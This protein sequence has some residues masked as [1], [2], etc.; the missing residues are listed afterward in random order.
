[1]R[2]PLNPFVFR[3]VT[4]RARAASSFCGEMS[5]IGRSH[6]GERQADALHCFNHRIL[7]ALNNGA[8]SLCT[9]RAIINDAA[10]AV[11]C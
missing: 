1:M 2:R 6:I 3:R 9:M 10:A 4:Q 8:G 11:Y 5:H 7:G